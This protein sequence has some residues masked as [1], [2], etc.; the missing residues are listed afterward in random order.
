MVG[1]GSGEVPEAESGRGTAGF[2]AAANEAATPADHV[3]VTTGRIIGAAID[4]HRIL[5]PGLLESTYAACFAEGLRERKLRFR[6]EVELP[7]R[8]KGRTLDQAYRIDFLVEELVVVELKAVAS[9]ENV[10]LSQLLT[11]LKHSGRPVGLLINFNVEVLTRGGVRRV[12]HR[13]HE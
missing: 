3:N 4:V 10:F 11:Y 6:R 2:D 1:H 9:V 13:L 12:V 7:V 5:G 8:F